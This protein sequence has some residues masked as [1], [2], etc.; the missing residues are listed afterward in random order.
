MPLVPCR[1]IPHII[2]QEILHK[3]QLVVPQFVFLESEEGKCWQSLCNHVVLSVVALRC[4]IQILTTE[5]LK[6]HVNK[7]PNG[8]GKGF[9]L[10]EWLTVGRKLD[11][12]PHF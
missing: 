10:A 7:Q 3:L 12:G 1:V 6:Q 4:M 8:K 2:L 9:I 11:L 5:G